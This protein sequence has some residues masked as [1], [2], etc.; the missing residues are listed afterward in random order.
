MLGSR[1]L[2]AC[3]LYAFAVPK[4]SFTCFSYLL[5][6]DVC[7]G[8]LASG[9]IFSFSSFGEACQPYA[10]VVDWLWVGDCGSLEELAY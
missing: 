2:T 3:G 9:F 10:V 6:V 8:R 4:H 7:V 5:F 1:T